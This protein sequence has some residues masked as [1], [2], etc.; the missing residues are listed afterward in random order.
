LHRLRVVSELQT[1]IEYDLVCF[2]S[3]P[4]GRLIDC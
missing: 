2:S 1:G 3:S 4:T